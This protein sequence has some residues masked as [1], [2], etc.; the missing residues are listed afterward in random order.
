MNRRVERPDPSVWNIH[1]ITY[2][3]I[4]TGVAKIGDPNLN[5]G[6]LRLMEPKAFENP[7]STLDPVVQ[8]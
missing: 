2:N 8:E 7:G 3:P 4:V 1:G 5:N 6:R